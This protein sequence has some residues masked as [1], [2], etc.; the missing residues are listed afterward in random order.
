MHHAVR[1]LPPARFAAKALSLAQNWR[2][3]VR[4]PVEA[5]RYLV[6][7]REISNWTYELQNEDEL[8]D[9]A[10]AMIGED[11]ATL[12][13]YRDELRDDA[14]LRESI[15]KLLVTSPRRDPEVRFG[16]RTMHYALV[17]AMKPKSVVE[18]G[19]HDGLGAVAVLK[20]LERN[21]E[22]GEVG[23]L[24]A[25]DD[26]PE[27][28]WLIPD[29]L[30]APMTRYEGDATELLE[31]ALA[32]HGVDFL[33]QDIGPGIG[34]ESDLFDAAVRHARG[35]VLI[36][37]ELDGRMNLEQYARRNQ[38]D[39]AWAQ[40]RPHRHFWQGTKIGLA[41]IRSRGGDVPSSGGGG[42][43]GRSDAPGGDREERAPHGTRMP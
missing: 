3:S 27:S 34:F 24:L 25:F 13:R 37:A 21:A 12:R 16:Y 17:R 20:A 32:E 19:V 23:K 14:D 41:R 7:S 11:P 4:H 18:L 30:K 2:S 40:E 42:I 31:P 6:R 5:L 26:S 8:L 39:F 43:P 1:D 38:G 22:D 15:E 33:I 10:A 35:D 36:R 29:E 28:G 9:M